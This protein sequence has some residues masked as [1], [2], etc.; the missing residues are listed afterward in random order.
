MIEIM[1]E[2]TGWQPSFF[3]RLINSIFGDEDEFDED[4]VPKTLKLELR[5]HLNKLVALLQGT[6]ID[7]KPSFNSVVTSP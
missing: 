6:Q 1:C 3:D 2:K 4:D 5:V 7:V